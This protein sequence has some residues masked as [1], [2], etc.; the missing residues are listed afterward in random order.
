[1]PN[2]V[3]PSPSALVTNQEPPVDQGV[4]VGAQHQSPASLAPMTNRNGRTES[5]DIQALNS[6]ISNEMA[7]EAEVP[8]TM[9]KHM[10]NMAQYSSTRQNTRRG[11]LPGNNASF[12]AGEQTRPRQRS[13]K[14]SNASEAARDHSI[15]ETKAE[16]PE[17]EPLDETTDKPCA[18][19]EESSM[20]VGH[21]ASPPKVTPAKFVAGKETVEIGCG[22]DNQDSFVTRALPKEPADLDATLN[23][24]AM[25]EEEDKNTCVESKVEVTENQ[26]TTESDNDSEMAETLIQKTYVEKKVDRLIKEFQ[27]ESDDESQIEQAKSEVKQKQV[28]EEKAETGGN[29]LHAL[30]EEEKKEEL[31]Q[32]A[33][34]IIDK[35]MA[36]DAAENEVNIDT[37]AQTAPDKLTGSSNEESQNSLSH[38]NS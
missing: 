31:S 7:K 11:E 36:S 21:E 18:K 23:D 14:F 22:P 2:F 33:N 29:A 24:R 37:V 8:P 28:E 10:S 35:L 13:I 15:E 9:A 6:A 30:V 34:Q 16:L 25:Q 27:T 3:L 19:K 17:Y 5:L 26:N 12:R 4:Q 38:S 1:M 20:F 32:A